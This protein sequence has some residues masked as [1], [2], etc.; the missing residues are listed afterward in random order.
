[1][2]KN[3][4]AQGSVTTNLPLPLSVIGH[5]H[6]A[7]HLVF[8]WWTP[9]TFYNNGQQIWKWD[10]ETKSSDAGLEMKIKCKCGE[11][12]NSC[13]DRN[14]VK[15]NLS[16]CVKDVVMLKRRKVHQRMMLV[17]KI[18]IV[19]NFT[20]VH[21]LWSTK[22]KTWQTDPNSERSVRICQSTGKMLSVF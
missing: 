16:T 2:F 17:K 14:S 7:S 22:D 13:A 20:V 1:M 9:M 15:A 18:H 5:R 10:I 6:P 4:C 19:R 21:Y 12:R 3:R 11:R 8:H